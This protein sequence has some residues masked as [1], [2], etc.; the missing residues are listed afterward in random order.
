MKKSI[1]RIAFCNFLSILLLQ[2]ISLISAPLFSRLLSTDGYGNL[3]SFTT[4]AGIAA[5]VLSLQTNATI[6]NARV[7]FPEE[8]QPAYQSAA[9]AISLLSFGIGALII[10]A[11]AGPISRGLKVEGLLIGLRLI[12][13]F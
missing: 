9:M 2:G 12:Q 13:A 1:N 8:E 6:V 4:W 10:A 7:K 3:A 5:T 11:F